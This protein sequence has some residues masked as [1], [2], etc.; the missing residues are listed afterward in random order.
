MA[1]FIAENAAKKNLKNK[2]TWRR[3]IMKKYILLFCVM[4]MCVM[5][6]FGCSDQETEK[7][8]VVS[9]AQPSSTD[10]APVV[11]YD[12]IS[13]QELT[14]TYWKAV[15]YESA[16]AGASAMPRDG[17]NVDVF[18]FEGGA[19]RFRSIKNN[20]YT[21]N[22]DI[23]ADCNWSVDAASGELIVGS[24]N[25]LTGRFMGGKMYVDFRG[26]TLCL[27]K[28]EMP[29]PGAQWC[30]ADLIGTWSL[31]SVEI[32]GYQYSAEEEGSH[33]SMSF[34]AGDSGITVNH[35]QSDV[36][37]NVT[38]IVDA[39]VKYEET[40]LYEGCE[41]EV[42]SAMFLGDDGSEYY[43][44]ITDRNTLRLLIFS[45]IAE[46]E[47]P[48]VCYQTYAWEGTGPVG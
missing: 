35:V 7:V 1:E 22:A 36:A 16:E 46:L 48:V 41:N 9:P 34:F 39:P 14:N 31:K 12:P 3:E 19:A 20:A 38:E 44:T 17:W 32:E 4:L 21:E 25:K 43:V 8:D 42:W 10:A 18:L 24:E 30:P 40:A 5:L 29:L 2:K 45:Y 37:G 28:A 15:S 33:G 26:G 6:L 23:Y 13:A 27:E 47:Y 11:E